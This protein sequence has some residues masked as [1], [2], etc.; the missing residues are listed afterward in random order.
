MPARVCVVMS[1]TVR[2]A[3]SPS[4]WS[5]G[6]TKTGRFWSSCCVA[7]THER[8]HDQKGT[9]VTEKRVALI[10]GAG[11]GIGKATALAFLRDG[12]RVAM[13]G[14]HADRLRAVAS[15][16]DEGAQTLCVEA[17]VTKPAE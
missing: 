1:R 12:F 2:S 8:K 17:D 13:A 6:S 16:A 7:V 3:A 14:R 9:E 15:E 5:S 11:S 4:T 10:T